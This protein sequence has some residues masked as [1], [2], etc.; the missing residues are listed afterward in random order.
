MSNSGITDVWASCR[1]RYNLYNKIANC[2]FYNFKKG[3]NIMKS[4]LLYALRWQAGTL[5]AASLLKIGLDNHSRFQ[6]FVFANFICALAFYNVDKKI[7]EIGNIKNKKS[8]KKTL[9][10]TTEEGIKKMTQKIIETSKTV[11]N[12]FV[13]PA[14]IVALGIAFCGFFP[15][16]YWNKTEG[17]K[18]Q[19]RNTV[20]VKGL[21]EKI[22]KS[23]LAT[24]SITVSGNYNDWSEGKR[25]VE[26]KTKEVLAFLNE[27]GLS[28]SEMREDEIEKD[29]RYYSSY[30]EVDIEKIKSRYK[31]SQKIYISTE[32][33]DVLNEIS[34]KIGKFRTDEIDISDAGITYYYFDLNEIKPE[35]LQDALANAKASAKKF[36]DESGLKVGKIKTASQGTFEILPEPGT[37]HYNESSSKNKLVRVVST[38][39]YYLK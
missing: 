36:A 9:I 10:Q 1:I 32:K 3:F 14:A 7:M 13:V 20:V 16:Y 29:D 35:M 25:S 30:R 19:E 4:F 6:A 34:F 17:D 21:A 38:I 31:I 33:V 2:V 8:K 27:M 15:G 12:K 37:S 23:N 22:V 28:S 18:L 39:E 11:E 5:L 24:W 26:E